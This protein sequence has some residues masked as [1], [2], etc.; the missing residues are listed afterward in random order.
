MEELDYGKEG[1]LCQSG[2]HV[3]KCY[4]NDEEKQKKQGSNIKVE[5][6]I[7]QVIWAF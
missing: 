4:Y 6:T 1:M 5:N 7:K 3:F 2:K